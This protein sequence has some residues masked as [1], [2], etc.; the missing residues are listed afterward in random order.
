[1]QE[2]A[3]NK[4][5]VQ[6]R[7]DRQDIAFCYDVGAG[8]KMSAGYEPLGP[9]GLYDTFG[10]ELSFGAALEKKLDNVAI[11]KFTHSGSQI[12]D[13][14]PKGS[15]TKSRNLYQRFLGF[16]TRAIGELQAKGH[17]VQLAGIFYHVGE[18]DMSFGPYRRGAAKRIESLVAG[19]RK[20]LNMPG[21]RWFLTQQE[22]TDHK[23]V[24]TT[25]V[26][27]Q[28]AAIAKNDP[29]LFHWKMFDLPG[30][31]RLVIRTPGI[32]ELGERMAQRYLKLGR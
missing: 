21:L 20:D 3:K 11:A 1:M 6:L 10:P 14:T 29:H 25:D 18:N 2:L 19:L 26:V 4:D 5:Y 13:W 31:E 30:R 16:I 32:V 15:F 7:N 9:I 23:R 24:N 17:E 28:V 12:I 27:A 8:F 22:P